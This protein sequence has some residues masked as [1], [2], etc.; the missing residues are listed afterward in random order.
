MS[1]TSS[2]DRSFIQSTIET[3]LLQNA[4]DWI[5]TNLEPDAVFTEA[6][7]EQWA[8]NNDFVKRNEKE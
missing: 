8:E 7:L 4:I 3:T 5:Q 6:Q 2:Q 1:T